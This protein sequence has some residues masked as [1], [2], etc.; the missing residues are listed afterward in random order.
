MPIKTFVFL[1]GAFLGFI[2]GVIVG[3]MDYDR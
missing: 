3:A 1:I 2:L